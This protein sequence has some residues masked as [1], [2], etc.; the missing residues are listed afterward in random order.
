MWM[1]FSIRKRIGAGLTAGVLGVMPLAGCQIQSSKPATEEM[2]TATIASDE[3]MQKRTWTPSSTTYTNDT[4]VAFPTLAPLSAAGDSQWNVFVDTGTFM[5]NS[6]YAPVGFF[7]EPDWV[8]VQYKSVSVP[9]TYTAMP[10]LPPSSKA[11]PAQTTG[12]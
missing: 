1:M 3:A 5:A 10:P 7:T 8:M 2:S 11:A 9:P 12:G 6:G 4:V